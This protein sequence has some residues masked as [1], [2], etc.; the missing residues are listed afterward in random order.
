VSVGGPDLLAVD[1]VLVTLSDCAGL[2]R[3]Q[4]GARARLGVALTPEDVTG[5]DRRQVLAFLLLGAVGVDHR[6]DHREAERA[7]PR[8]VRRLIFF[9]PDVTLGGSPAGAA[10]FLRPCRRDPALF[11][12]DLVPEAH[13]FLGGVGGGTYHLSPDVL[14]PIVTEASTDRVTKGAVL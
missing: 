8:R 1:D 9:A 12:E 5:K 11:V 4:V 10:I 7:E 6:P 2:Q 13:G 3:R 14:R